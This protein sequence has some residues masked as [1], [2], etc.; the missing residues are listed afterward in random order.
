MSADWW[1]YKTHITTEM[2]NDTSLTIPFYYME[3][4]VGR[5]EITDENGDG[6]NAFR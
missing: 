3:L 6:R 2:L 4:Y 1:N 5:Y